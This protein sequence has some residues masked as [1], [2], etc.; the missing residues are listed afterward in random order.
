M[1]PR[2]GGGPRGVL[3]A[4]GVHVLATPSADGV[5]FSGRSGVGGVRHRQ[6]VQSQNDDDVQVADTPGADGRHGSAQLGEVQ[7]HRQEDERRLST[8]GA[9][10]SG[11]VSQKVAEGRQRAERAE[12]EKKIR[13]VRAP[14]GKET[15]AQETEKAGQKVSLLLHRGSLARACTGGE[16][17]HPE[18]RASRARCAGRIWNC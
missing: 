18:W 16:M 10:E 1:R 6:L 14:R 15:E 11:S 2:H 17:W 5:L 3:A 13:Q 12:E 7:G 9:T 8:G 4:T